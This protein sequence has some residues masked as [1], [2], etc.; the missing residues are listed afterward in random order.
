MK[1]RLI[2]LGV[3]IGIFIIIIV[4]SF[5]YL[6]FGDRYLISVMNKNNYIQD[7][8][9]DTVYTKTTNG[10]SIDDYYDNLDN[11]IETEYRSFSFFLD[12]QDFRDFYMYNVNDVNNII[13]I[14]YSF[15]NDTTTFEYEILNDDS[16]DIMITGTLSD[17][18]LS[19]NS[20]NNISED[21][22][23]GY[24]DIVKDEMVNFMKEKN[25]FVSNGK[26]VKNMKSLNK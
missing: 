14:I 19:C 18:Q 8:I 1:K 5:I 24:C 16:K 3:M 2:I 6:S 21:Y 20:D 9:E 22:L 17:N 11:L 12:S 25:K 13:Q 26:F 15:K 23:N 4:S 7:D 10:K